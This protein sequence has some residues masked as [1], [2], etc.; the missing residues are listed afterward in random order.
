MYAFGPWLPDQPSFES[1]ACSDVLNVIPSEKGYRP[2]NSF[3]NVTAA[4]TAR[5]QGAFTCRGKQGT[6]YNFCGDATK[7][8]KQASNGL[9]WGD[10]SR[11]AGGAYAAASDGWWDFALFGDIVIAT[12]GVDAPQRFQLDVDSNFT[13]LAGSPPVA[14]FV[15]VIRD[16]AVLASSAT[17]KS[18]LTWSALGNCEDW[19]A[20]ATTL[21]DAQTM[22]EGSAIMGGVGGEYGVLFQ[23]RAI[24]R[25]S[26]EGSPTVFRFDRISNS[27]GCRAERSIATYENMIFFLS[28]DGMK[29]IHGGT[30]SIFIGSEK[31]D[32]WL[33]TELGATYLFRISSAID[34][35][36]KIYLMSFPNGSASSGTPNR[37][38][39]FHWPTGKFAPISPGDHELIYV[40]A[41]QE[42][43]TIDGLDAL[44]GTID[45][46]PYPVDSRFYA[47]SGQLLLSAFNTSHQQGFYTGAYLAATVETGDVQLTPGFKS[48]LRSLR[49]LLEGTSLTTTVTIKYRNRLQDSHSTATAVAV[50]A[51]GVCPVR[52]NA[53]YHRATINTAAS[54]TWTHANGV[55]DIVAVKMGTR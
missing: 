38:L 4:T 31:V 45:G 13:A 46:L 12:N 8:Y 29:M 35:I 9:T 55:D 19:V 30:E 36:K 49:P 17:D 21:S 48:L 51:N 32:R 7:L 37:I 2:V 18:V 34:P 10:V 27:M 20:S 14:R 47:G 33:E 53:R 39:V 24:S 1:G 40:G 5:A 44:S 26:F 28:N 15:F 25:M 54:D 11:L 6:I 41:T 16:F 50:N 42:T 22:Y 43:Y 3:Y 52:V 23:E